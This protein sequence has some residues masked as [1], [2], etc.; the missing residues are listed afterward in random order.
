ME[1]IE[2]IVKFHGFDELTVIE[3]SGAD[4]SRFSSGGPEIDLWGR[5][6]GQ[7][8]PLD[9]CSKECISEYDGE[10]CWPMCRLCPLSRLGSSRLGS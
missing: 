6:V 3:L 4:C 5:H 9:Q 2:E 8:L 7:F 1:C 10:F